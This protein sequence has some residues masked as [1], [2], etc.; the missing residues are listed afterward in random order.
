MNSTVVYSSDAEATLS[1]FW[2]NSTNRAVITQAQY[3]IDRILAMDP[4]QGFEVREVQIKVK[5]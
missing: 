1:T 3:R 2:I 4:F 5:S